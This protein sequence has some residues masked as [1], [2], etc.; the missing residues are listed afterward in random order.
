MM[1]FISNSIETSC[2]EADIYNRLFDYSGKNIL[3]LGCGAAALTRA[4]AE[5]HPDCHIDALEV[6]EIQHGKNI[7][8]RDLPNVS[9][10]LAGAQAIP[11]DDDSYDI[12]FMFKS[13]HHVPMEFMEKALLEIKRVLKPGGMAY[14]SEPVYA[15][16]F[17]DLMC[18]FH[19]EKVVRE[20]A[21]ATLEKAIQ[22]GHFELKEEIFFNSPVHF[23][24]FKQFET[25][26]LGATFNNH[27]LDEQT[28]DRVREKFSLNMRASGADFKLPIR[29]DLLQ[30]S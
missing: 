16:E 26:V 22:A 17:N 9:F 19:D 2:P 13:L 3:E 11:A 25:E 18:L 29:V 10:V 21:F 14:I 28:H 12:V 1:Q 4:I 7:Q 27:Q 23:A 24:D 15:G 8:I 30:V 6:D 5:A 20:H